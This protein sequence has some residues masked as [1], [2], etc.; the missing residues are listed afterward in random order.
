[1]T[2]VFD[3]IYYILWLLL[4]KRKASFTSFFRLINEVEIIR[5]DCYN[6]LRNYKIFLLQNIE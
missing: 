5:L 1:M 6:I 4:K 3:I 2:L